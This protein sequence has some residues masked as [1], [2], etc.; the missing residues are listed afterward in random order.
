[1]TTEATRAAFAF[2]RRGMRGRQLNGKTVMDFGCGAICPFDMSSLFWLNGAARCVAVDMAGVAN[3]P[4]AARSLFDLLTA[5]KADPA[6]FLWTGVDASDFLR[7]IDAFD[8]DRLGAG[9]FYR[10]IKDATLVHAIGRIEHLPFARAS[11]DMVFSNTVIEHVMN[12]PSVAARFAFLLS[13][14][15]AM[16]HVVDYTDHGI[17]I[18]PALNYWSFLT[19][20]HEIPDIEDGGDMNKLRNSEVEAIFRAG[21]FNV[22]MDPLIRQTPPAEVVQTLLPQYR[23]MSKDDLELVTTGLL[24]TPRPLSS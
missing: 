16:Y 21:G 19:E 2:Y 22:Q 3:L 14:Y 17:H 15:G 1:M 4:A 5:C 10:G 9:E 13:P 24:L 8:L 11:F 6:P 7:R 18:D 20:G 12:L 23:A